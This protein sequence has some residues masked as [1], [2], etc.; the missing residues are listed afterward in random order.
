MGWGDIPNTKKRPARKKP[1]PPR[2]AIRRAGGKPKQKR[3][4]VQKGPWRSG[5]KKSTARKEERKPY[6]KAAAGPPRPGTRPAPGQPGG[7][8]PTPKNIERYRREKAIHPRRYTPGY[9]PKKYHPDTAARRQEAI[10]GQLLTHEHLREQAISGKK[11]NY[12]MADR[13]LPKSA[14]PAVR[15][16]LR[17][18]KKYRKQMEVARY[19]L[20]TKGKVTK[21]SAPSAVGGF[22]AGAYKDT[23]GELKKAQD[24]WFKGAGAAARGGR[25]GP[26]AP[27]VGEQAKAYLP[28]V[29][30]V[31][32]VTGTGIVAKQ[33]IKRAGKEIAEEGGTKVVA[34]ALGKEAKGL[35][36]RAGK[37]I[38][39]KPAKVKAAVKQNLRRKANII[40]KP[41]IAGKRLKGKGTAIKRRKFREPV[42][43]A[44]TGTRYSAVSG[45]VAQPVVDNPVGRYA[46]HHIKAVGEDPK[47]VAGTTA[48]A[49]PGVVTAPLSLAA[50]VGASI[51]KKDIGPAKHEAESVIDFTKQ[52]A[53]VAGKDEKEAKR[54]V[55]EE[56]GLIGLTP[57]LSLAGRRY[58]RKARPITQDKAS[59]VFGRI[60]AR[61]RARKEVARAKTR[62]QT[63]VDHELEA[64]TRHTVQK[65]AAHKTTHDVKPE[66]ALGFVMELGLQRPT[67]DITAAARVQHKN[68]KQ[69]EHIYKLLD[70]LD[71]PATWKDKNFRE[72][73]K[74]VREIGAS[75]R[76]SDRARFHE[77]LRVLGLRSVDEVIGDA[78]RRKKDTEKAAKRKGRRATTLI[79]RAGK[80]TTQMQERASKK[81]APYKPG[82]HDP[83]VPKET[84]AWLDAKEEARLAAQERTKASGRVRV[85]SRKAGLAEGRARYTERGKSQEVLKTQPEYLEAQAQLKK[86][87][88]ELDTAQRNYDNA[89][90]S[91]RKLWTD[92]DRAERT[93]ALYEAKQNRKAAEKHAKKVTEEITKTAEE[94]A[95]EK[96]ATPKGGKAQST[97]PKAISEHQEML[98]AIDADIEGAR[99]KLKRARKPE[100]KEEHKARIKKLQEVRDSIQERRPNEPREGYEGRLDAVN[101]E[102]KATQDAIREAAKEERPALREKLD[103]LKQERT[104]LT[105]LPKLGRQ[106]RRDLTRLENARAE[107]HAAEQRERTLREELKVKEHKARVAKGEAPRLRPREV[108]RLLFA[109]ADAEHAR[110]RHEEAKRE[111]EIAEKQYKHLAAGGAEKKAAAQVAEAQ[112]KYGLTAPETFGA[113]DIRER[114]SGISESGAEV[115][116]NVGKPGHKSEFILSDAGLKEY[117]GKALLE[118]T[119][120]EP[121]KQNALANLTLEILERGALP[122][123]VKDGSGRPVERTSV[124][125]S[126]AREALF[127]E[128]ARYDPAQVVVLPVR[129]K[130]ALEQMAKRQNRL[131]GKEL[132]GFETG[133]RVL[134]DQISNGYVQQLSGNRRDTL[135][136]VTDDWDRLT[137]R[138]KTNQKAGGK[139]KRE[140]VIIMDREVVREWLSQVSGYKDGAR[141]LVNRGSNAMSKAI[142]YNP[143]WALSQVPATAA[144]GAFVSPRMRRGQKRLRELEKTNP[145]AA[146]KISAHAGRAPAGT[147]HAV[148]QS[149]VGKDKSKSAK[150]QKF[151]EWWADLS[152]TK[153]GR[154][155]KKAI[156]F[157][158]EFNKWSEGAIRTGVYSAKLISEANSRFSR[159]HK[160]HKEL[161][162]SLQGK[163]HAQQLEILSRQDKVLQRIADDTLAVIGDFRTLTRFEQ[164]IAPYVLFYPFMRMSLKFLFY[165]LPAKH[166][167]KAMAAYTLAQWNAEELK[168][169]LGAD[170]AFFAEWATVMARTGEG[171]DDI[172]ALFPVT[173]IAPGG[174]FVPEMVGAAATE[175][176]KG[177]GISRGLNPIVGGIDAARHS[178]DPVSGKKLREDDVSSGRFDQELTGASWRSLKLAGSTSLGSAAPA[179]GA[180]LLFG[181]DRKDLTSKKEQDALTKLT[182]KIR[183]KKQRGVE[184]FLSPVSYRSPTQ[185]KEQAQL[186]EAFRLRSAGGTKNRN[187]SDELL[188]GLF[189]KYGLWKQAERERAEFFAAKYGQQ[190]GPRRPKPPK[191]PSPPSR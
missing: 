29:A 59:T 88:L 123:A 140:D 60:G 186:A 173:R 147:G 26:K 61:H 20:T 25:G 149:M 128:D 73:A 166:P 183:G 22:F 12:K 13:V 109:R 145:E 47:K 11:I 2:E 36:R 54:I 157:P 72:A 176:G 132:E 135:K 23:K 182:Y 53:K 104:S 62:E 107:L 34:K 98:D 161:W 96:A 131:E 152:R 124:A 171:K 184:Q 101:A 179:R 111:A 154:G 139:G 168:K 148:R 158:G 130:T 177:L 7:R 180:Q 19:G 28:V 71:D 118:R 151:R 15:S 1:P 5:L 120:V 150:L 74:A 165:G 185:A 66:D 83:E 86:T 8:R 102:I 82:K 100:K 156:D 99:G 117:T 40:K 67:P 138:A 172:G 32:G 51:V 85:E 119:I 190:K 134:E 63:R 181:L 10:R 30:N 24:T 33:A 191:P 78:A 144:V 39:K 160:T 52:M 89:H 27:T 55:K 108:D 125:M 95:F 91:A 44:K 143:A 105:Q 4:K 58:S 169:F 136:K 87:G 187:K 178:I 146:W 68:H 112:E 175:E 35:P 164:N 133:M 116:P 94:L 127:G 189:K 93:Q 79:R 155:T 81:R 163:T 37:A 14:M 142:L 121:A 48:R 80:I 50:G 153:T 126:Q 43:L 129:F 106:P 65:A 31:A 122:V 113:V 75:Q 103:A 97:H 77:L 16:D 45:T 18:L 3:D 21:E 159:L 49:A 70:F 167:Y 84:Q 9:V 57:A 170:P 76:W 137:E 6:P 64:K 188:E 92:K 174:S 110:R 56:L 69:R 17:S 90:G 141:E 114:P 46:K 42:H 41:S 38:Y 162:D 115:P